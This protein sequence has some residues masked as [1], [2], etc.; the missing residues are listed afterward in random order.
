MSN[1][2]SQ[3]PRSRADVQKRPAKETLQKLK[4]TEVPGQDLANFEAR[5]SEFSKEFA[6]A[7]GYPELSKE[8]PLGRR[9]RTL[10]ASADDIINALPPLRGREKVA[11]PPVIVRPLNQLA[12]SYISLLLAVA[13]DPSDLSKVAPRLRDIRS[14]LFF[15]LAHR[16]PPTDADAAAQYQIYEKKMS[17]IGAAHYAFG[18]GTNDI[19]HTA[20]PEGLLKESVRTFDEVARRATALTE[21][22]RSLEPGERVKI[23]EILRTDLEVAFLNSA[24]GFTQKRADFPFSV[25]PSSAVLSEK[26]R[27]KAPKLK[28]LDRDRTLKQTPVDFIRTVY[29]DRLGRGFTQADLGACDK[30]LYDAFH[31]WQQKSDPATGQRNVV[32]IDFDLPTVEE[33]NA[34]RLRQMEIAP[35]TIDADERIRLSKVAVS[36]AS[37]AAKFKIKNGYRS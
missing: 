6:E 29:R 1:K 5:E 33:W 11:V 20:V 8:T 17:V 28:W 35:E 7:F 37:R 3:P 15:A 34:R 25:L 10:R 22:I 13:S 24:S 30:S 26:A 27:R 32:P 2:T 19:E 16:L 9:L 31:Q 21:D 23:V 18:I 4:R 12:N 14:S 36:R